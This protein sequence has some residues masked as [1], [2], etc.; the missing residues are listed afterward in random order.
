[1]THSG[2]T[3]QA[4]QVALHGD[5]N[6]NPSVFV[7]ANVNVFEGVSTT[8]WG[9]VSNTGTGTIQL[10]LGC[11]VGNVWSTGN[12]DLPGGSATLVVH[13][14]LRTTGTADEVAGQ[15]S[16][17]V[18]ESAVITLG[19]TTILAT[20]PVV[21]GS[22]YS[23]STGT[24]TIN[25]GAINDIFVDGGTLTINQGSYGAL[26]VNG[27]TVILNQG[28]YTFTNVT[29][30]PNGTLQANNG[31]GAV[32]IHVRETMLFRGAC[33]SFTTA[34]L[35]WVVFGAGGAT[36]GPTTSATNVFRGT[37]V[38]MNGPMII[39]DG[40]RT[41]RGGFFGLSVNVHANATIQHMAFGFW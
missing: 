19:T 9:I 32:H 35:R 10:D 18:F 1:M 23:I 6:A 26:T 38:A 36:L 37:V 33:T 22:T 15:V 20:F 39:E 5:L 29:W 7:A 8:A 3:I 14:S 11:D 16:G 31:G 41:Y 34:N 4:S 28:T 27:G 21:S 12:V 25:P 17:T 30:N 24:D 2:T 40:T 13:G